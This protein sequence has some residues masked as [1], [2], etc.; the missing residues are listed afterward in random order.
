VIS[1]SKFKGIVIWCRGSREEGLGHIIRGIN[2]AKFFKKKYDNITLIFESDLHTMSKI[3]EKK[4][5][6]SI[7][8]KFVILNENPERFL[9]R[10]SIYFVDRYVYDE[11]IFRLIKNYSEKVI[12]FDELQQIE[13]L[14]LF[15][16]ND[17]LIQSQLLTKQKKQKRKYSCKLLTG[18][19]YFVI[20]NAINNSDNVVLQ[21]ERNIDILVMLGGGS[22]YENYYLE[23]ANSL[24][25]S[26]C[27][28]N[29]VTFI[30]GD[31]YSEKL[32]KDIT[33]I[34]Q[35]YQVFGFVDNPMQYMQNSK[36]GIM[37]GGYSKYE[38]A[39]VGM[40]TIVLPVQDHQISIA[41]EFCEHGGGIYVENT[42]TLGKE[43]VNL[44]N[45]TSMLRTMSILSK[46]M[47]DG[48]ALNRIE[49]IM[50]D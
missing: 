47:I 34:N 21:S 25:K 10:A 29:K 43:V 13:F 6:A 27:N 28:F 16:K 8:C 40:P 22:G 38:A 15:S 23:V 33:N 41:K 26:K 32:L 17:I 45:N 12:V 19:R 1:L 4:S 35:K 18:L 50:Q 24:D 49:S 14:D 20:N 37:S 9:E 44:F 7:N 46:Q 42:K 48:K 30:L 2:V 36:I 5:I 31:G 3:K 11:S 39:H